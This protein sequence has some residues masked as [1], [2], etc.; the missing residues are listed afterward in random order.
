MVVS[1]HV[2]LQAA[3][4]RIAHAQSLRRWRSAFVA[5]PRV[6]LYAPPRWAVAASRCSPVAA[7]LLRAGVRGGRRPLRRA[8]GGSGL[9]RLVVGRRLCCVRLVFCL[10]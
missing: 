3:S 7:G 5:R 4:S 2:Q 10:S 8:A 6:L 9:I 1:C